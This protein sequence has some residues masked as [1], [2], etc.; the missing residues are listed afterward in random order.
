MGAMLAFHCL[1][2]SVRP[3]MRNRWPLSVSKRPF[4]PKWTQENLVLKNR[5]LECKYFVSGRKTTEC[6]KGDEKAQVGCAGGRGSEMDWGFDR[7]NSRR[8]G[9][10][11]LQE[12][13]NT[14]MA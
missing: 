13:K 9:A 10:S 14:N 2:R 11:S 6:R 7:W 3:A 5:N 4:A 8:E 12:V 1:P